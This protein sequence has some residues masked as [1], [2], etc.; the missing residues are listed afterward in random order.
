MIP[1]L[2]YRWQSRMTETG[3]ALVYY[4]LRNP[5]HNARQLVSLTPAAAGAIARMDGRTG[6][7]DIVGAAAGEL[8]ALKALGA[9]VDRSEVTAA[10][11]PDNHRTCA[12]CVNNDWVIPGLEFDENGV[13]AFCQCYARGDDG[14][15]S[16][17]QALSESALKEAVGVTA[18]S[19][20]DVM[21]LYTGGKDSSFLVWHMARNLGLRVLAAFWNMPYCQPAAYDNIARAKRRLPEVSFVEW[22]LPGETVTAAMR[23]QLSAIGSACL[24]PTAAFPLFYPLAHQHRIPYILFGME[25]VQ[26]AVVDYVFPRPAAPAGCTGPPS[27]R[28]RTLAFLKMRALPRALTAPVRWETEIANY[29]ASVQHQLSDFFGPLQ[30]IIAQAEAD[31]DLPIPLITRLNTRESYGSWKDVIDLLGRELDWRMPDGQENMLHTSCRIEPVKDYLQYMRFKQMRTVFFPQSMVEI[32]ASVFFG[33]I[34]REEGL[35]QARELGYVHP[36]PVLFELLD[37]LGIDDGMI[38][39]TKTELDFVLAEAL[40]H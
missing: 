14:K 29:H 16:F 13:C 28:E 3:P 1:T 10:P 26:A 6:W 15:P 32:S 2:Q 30:D 12:T 35:K 9:I 31:A 27:P 18:G 8:A 4:G 22:T 20:F 39:N 37:D 17:V 34:S 23:G 21:V 38:G 11:G 7:A 5:P 19:R 25:D 33:M 40:S 36:P 24:C